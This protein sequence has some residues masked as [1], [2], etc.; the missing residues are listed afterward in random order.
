M[1]YLVPLLLFVV[2]MGFLWKGLQQDPHQL[3]SALLNK[4]LPVF[5]YPDLFKPQQQITP[6]QFLG[7][8]T[9]LNVWATWCVTCQVEHPTFVDIAKQVNLIGLNYKDDAHAAIQ[10]LQQ[11]TNPYQRVIFDPQGTLGIDLGVY[12][13]PETFLIDQQ[14]II[15]YKFIGPITPEVWQQQ[16]LPQVRKWQQGS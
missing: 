4:P 16:L 11:H 9:L 8:V 10:W 13:T 2:V 1:R 15:R 12:G 14:G 7:K 3:S 6:Q 5:S